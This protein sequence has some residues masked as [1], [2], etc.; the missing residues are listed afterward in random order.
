MSKKT[1][2]N[3]KKYDR[4]DAQPDPEESVREVRLLS[5]TRPSP[6]LKG[7]VDFRAQDTATGRAFDCCMPEDY[8]V[9]PV[10]EHRHKI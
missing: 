7:C 8:P 9:K 1:L 4:F 5:D 10:S 6:D 2:K 3:G